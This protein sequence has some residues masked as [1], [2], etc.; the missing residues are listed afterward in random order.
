M[1]YLAIT[2]HDSLAAYRELTGTPGAIPA[3]LELISGVEIN[4]ISRDIP[5]A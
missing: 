1:R 4:A 2:D 5:L 3:G